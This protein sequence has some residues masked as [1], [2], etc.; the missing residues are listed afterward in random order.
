[1][2]SLK[3]STRITLRIVSSNAPQFIIDG[4]DSPETVVC[5]FCFDKVT[6]MQGCVIRPCDH[7]FHASCFIEDFCHNNTSRCPECRSDYLY[8]PFAT[9]TSPQPM[10]SIEYIGPVLHPDNTSSTV[11]FTANPPYV[12]PSLDTLDTSVN[13]ISQ[14]QISSMTRRR[15]P[16]RSARPINLTDESTSRRSTRRVSRS[17]S[18]D[19]V[20]NNTRRITRTE[21][22]NQLVQLFIQ[23]LNTEQGENFIGLQDRME[24]RHNDILQRIR[25]LYFES[26]RAEVNA[27]N[28]FHLAVSTIFRFGEAIKDMYMALLSENGN[29]HNARVALNREIEALFPSASSRG[30]LRK[31]SR[32]RN[33]YEIFSAVGPEKISRIRSVQLSFFSELRSRDI[34]AIKVAC[35]G[36]LN[37]LLYQ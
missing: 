32:V 18:T 12:S 15:N 21:R 31:I 22:R 1:M 6:P 10:E 30:V 11:D 27:N 24:V 13:P 19:R 3:E 9:G 23:D 26:E 35:G 14:I 16:N 20:T 29:D 4:I 7:V 36:N 33:V 17:Q 25:D 8:E 2:A 34:D 5:C 28:A 37:N